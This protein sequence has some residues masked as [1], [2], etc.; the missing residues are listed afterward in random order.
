[1]APSLVVP[2]VT[3]TVL[4]PR[5]RYERIGEPRFTRSLVPATKMIGEKAT[6]CCRSRLLVVEPHSRYALPETIASMRVSDVT[7]SHL[8]ASSRPIAS[9]SASASFLHSSIEYPIGSPP[10]RDTQKSD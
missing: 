4:P 10:L 9:P 6:C 5:L 1:M 2:A 7:G 8:S 3:T